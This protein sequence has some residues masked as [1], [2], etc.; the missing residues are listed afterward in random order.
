MSGVFAG[1]QAMWCPV[2]VEMVTELTKNEL[3]LWT[4][5]HQ[6]GA[7]WGRATPSTAVVCAASGLTETRLHVAK[8]GLIDK[9]YLTVEAQFREGRQTYNRYVA[10]K[11][12]PGW[13]VLPEVAP[14]PPAA[15]SGEGAGSR[16]GRVP[17][18][19]TPEGAGSRHPDYTETNTHQSPPTPQGGTDER[20]VL[21]R[22]LIPDDLAS[23][24]DLFMDWW[25]HHKGGKR[26]QRALAGQIAELRKILEASDTTALSQQIQQGIDS[27]VIGGRRWAGI[28][29]F[30]FI[31]YRGLAKN[32]ASGYGR[33]AERPGG[34][35]MPFQFDFAGLA[36]ATA[37]T[38]TP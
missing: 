13:R 29:F 30:N 18:T 31:Q 27:S 35:L 32:G 9:G 38:T 10:R 22:E 17:K 7:D 4:A 28:T 15:P 20:V 33:P 34:S 37:P 23:I 21:T 14:E 3:L 1:P 24:A 36:P 26:T 16:Q 2:T 19:G 25:N 8:R 12:P 11:A 6:F 5:L